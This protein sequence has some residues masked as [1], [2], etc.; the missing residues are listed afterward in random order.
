M[1]LRWALTEALQ[2]EDLLAG[3]S[4]VVRVHGLKSL[5]SAGYVASDDPQVCQDADQQPHV[6]E[7]QGRYRAWVSKQT[8]HLRRPMSLLLA[9]MPGTRLRLFAN[10]RWQLLELAVGD[11]L[12]FAGDVKHNGVGYPGE[13]LRIHAHLYPPGYDHVGEIQFSQADLGTDD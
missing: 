2:E 13:H 4:A 10:R 3:G 6:D 11:V 12:V 7:E 9:I 8:D 1:C 5:P